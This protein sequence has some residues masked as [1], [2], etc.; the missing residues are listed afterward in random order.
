MAVK[1]LKKLN[2]SVSVSSIK[3]ERD[4][5]LLID[6]SS[7]ELEAVRVYRR[8]SV[9]LGRSE[10][11]K[12]L[13]SLGFKRWYDDYIY[14]DPEGNNH[15]MV[16]IQDYWKDDGSSSDCLYISRPAQYMLSADAQPAPSPKSIESQSSSSVFTS[17]VVSEI[18]SVID[19]YDLSVF[20]DSEVLEDNYGDREA[21]SSMKRPKEISDGKAAA[22]FEW[23]ESVVDDVLDQSG[24]DV[25]LRDL[26]ES[27]E[28]VLNK[29]EDYFVKKHWRK[30]D[31][32]SVRKVLTSILKNSGKDQVDG[33][34]GDSKLPV[35][36][37]FDEFSDLGY[38]FVFD[39]SRRSEYLKLSGEEKIV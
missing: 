6:P 29:I 3:D 16:S 23:G 19:D 9:E 15:W 18:K 14:E 11:K 4:L 1:F 32:P 35:I 37:Y 34:V 22:R 31:D 24:V 27:D 8:F 12:R 7:K 30:F 5:A 28:K 36:A 20:N 10:I 26:S 25:D 33:F 38:R 13:V 21:F 2:E 39:R 17:E